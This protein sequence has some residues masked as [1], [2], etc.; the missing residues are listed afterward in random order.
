MA[1]LAN[2]MSNERDNQ[3]WDKVEKQQG[4][5]PN[6]YVMGQRLQQVQIVSVFVKGE[7]GNV[8]KSTKDYRTNF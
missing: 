8:I 2:E 1:E 7:L 6:Q 3:L 4:A 5:M